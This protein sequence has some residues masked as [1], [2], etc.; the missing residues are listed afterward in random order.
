MSLV[1]LFLVSCSKKEPLAEYNFE[2]SGNRVWIGEDFWTVPLE[3]W[4][5]SNGRVEFTG[6]GQQSTCSLLPYQ[7]D[8]REGSFYISLEMGLLERGNND[9]ASGVVIGSKD[10]VDDDLKAAVYFGRGINIGVNT[11]GYAFIGQTTRK[12]PTDFDYS[13]FMLVITGEKGDKGFNITLRVEDPNK[14]SVAEI[15]HQAES[16]VSGIIQLVNNFRSAASKNSGPRFWYDN[17]HL[18]GRGLLY[19]PEERFGPV[20]WTM[21]TL[22][23]STL[24]LTAQMPPVGA[25]DNQELELQL[26]KDNKWVR[27]DV[28]RIE[29]DSRTATFKV[30]GWDSGADTEY[31]VLYPFTDM[32]G[33]E[34]IFEYHGTIRR[35][36]VDRPL[37]MGAMTCQYH[38]GFPYSP[39]VESLKAKNPDILYFSGDQIYEQNGGYPIKRTPEDA[40]ILNYLGKWYMFGWAFGDLMR[41]IPAICTPD[42]HDVFHG[43]LWGG[44]GIAR[45]SGTANSDDLMG[46]TQSVGMVNVVNTTQCAHLP[47]PFDPAPIEQ[48]MKVWY[49]SLNYGRVSFA[50]VSDRVF[51]SGP[52]LVATWEGRKDHLKEPLKD[53]SVI[54]RPE[55]EMLGKRQE[56]FLESW[57]REWKDV[58][59]K[60]LLSQTLFANVATHHGQFDGY[61]LGDLDSGGWPK[62]PRDRAVKMIRK[63]FAFHIAGDQHV[64][65]LVQYGIDDFRD[66]GWCFCTPAIAV[67][68][69]RWFRPDEIGIPAK[70]RPAHAFPN[71]GEYVDAFG[72]LNYV[73]AIGNPRDFATIKDRYLYQ[74]EKTAGLGF[75]IFDNDTRN[76]TMESW[77]FLSDVVKPDGESQ[78]PGWPLTISQMDN[79]G[80]NAEA[81][82]PDIIIEGEPDPVIEI[83]NQ[84]TGELEY[85]VRIKGTAFSPKVFSKESRYKVIAGHPEKGNYKV[86]DNIKPAEK[87]GMSEL[88]VKLN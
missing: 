27:A 78:H 57:I 8:E 11:A 7:L 83:T 70:N 65:S 17:L 73:Y 59:M 50:I 86:F 34:R 10:P 67:G 39:V 75:V 69:S 13:R 40:S 41:D 19:N 51:K 33:K 82:L 25:D 74:R 9:G 32:S 37:K 88:I 26:K 47:D 28:S 35:D 6:E 77:R 18:S 38:T 42:D 54:N 2:S 80:R 43:N 87:R 72:N 5:V 12:L 53:P 63:G 85:I 16:T 64:P 66:A 36:P 46:F 14:N 23:R 45:P 52:N 3:D 61:L 20:L 60:V 81:W 84:S 58:D 4:K 15:I 62:G 1:L 24:K 79:Y 31:K 76:I 55:L 71:T 68:Y 29:E 56:E 21:H 44:G 49:T 30:E 22:S 48:G